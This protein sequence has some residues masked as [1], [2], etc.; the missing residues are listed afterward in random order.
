MQSAFNYV[1]KIL[2]FFSFILI[3]PFTEAIL[4]ADTRVIVAIGVAIEVSFISGFLLDRIFKKEELSIKNAFIIASLSWILISI[5]G[6]IPYIMVLK[7]PIIDALFESVSGYTTTG[8]TVVTPHELPASLL[9]YRSYTQ[10]IGGTGVVLLFIVVAGPL[11]VASK[12]YIAEGRTERIEPSIVNTASRIFYLYSLLTLSGALA[13]YLSGLNVFDSANY[14]L[15]A[16]A[17]GGFSTRDTSFSDFNLYERLV[18]IVI[19]FIGAVSFA[20][21]QKLFSLD[22]KAFI[23]NVEIKTMVV[24]ILIFT[25]ILQSEIGLINALFQ[26]TSSITCTG[27]S[28]INIQELSEFGRLCLIFLMFTGGSYG[29]T[30]GA[31]KI[32][33][34]IVVLKSIEWYIKKLISPRGTIIPFKIGGKVFK[35]EE[36]FFTLSYVL[37]Y[38]CFIFSGTLLFVKMGHPLID[39]LFEIASAQGNVGLNSISSYTSLE[40]S[41]LIFFMIIGRL[42]IIPVLV[43][44]TLMKK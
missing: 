28:T 6:S 1:G 2:K 22:F 26:V 27:L 16:I 25:F 39:S 43:L 18:A 23:R 37:L 5:I 20:V 15:T 11:S 12:L 21:H 30:A 44:F 40:K 29:S 8:L 35:E 9:F 7:L 13:F 17:T 41:I 10:W 36:I 4:L 3:L 32:I 34:F 14:V 42:E 24:L 38:F 19:M 33:R 31:L